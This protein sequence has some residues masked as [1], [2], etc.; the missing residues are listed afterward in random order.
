MRI[1]R[2]K[3]LVIHLSLF[4]SMSDTGLEKYAFP[5]QT[6]KDI[7]AYIAQLKAEGKTFFPCGCDE[8][9]PDGSCKG[10]DEVSK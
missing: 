1:E 7:R 9:N 8:V 5:G 6:A 4:D 3:H 10:Y 2:T